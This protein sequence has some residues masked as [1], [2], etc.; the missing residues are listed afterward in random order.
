[1]TKGIENMLGLPHLDD[2]MKSRDVDFKNASIAPHQDREEPEESPMLAATNDINIDK[3]IEDNLKTIE[4]T[5]HA[6]S[7]DTIFEETLDHS[8]ALMDLGFN[9]DDRS[10]RGIFEI[11]SA[12]YKNAIDAKNSKRDAQ[13]K[14]MKMILDQ[15]KQDFDERRWRAERG[16]AD[17]GEVQGTAIL[18]EEDRN[19]LVKRAREAGLGR[20]IEEAKPE[21]SEAPVPPEDVE[22]TEAELLP[23]ED[24][25][26]TGDD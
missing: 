14:L 7:M 18:V 24:E 26:P 23:E 9:V 25:T 19:E 8:R 13:L 22:D 3:M 21:K 16:E 10:R 11:A 20:R 6:K 15:R 5:D 1:M 4:G 2:I 12:M 17:P